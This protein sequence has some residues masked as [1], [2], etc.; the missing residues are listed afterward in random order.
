[1][2]GSRGTG[3]GSAA[4]PAPY[5]RPRSGDALS[6]STVL[7]VG[8]TGVF[9]SRLALGLLKE[10]GLDLVIAGR[11]LGAADAFCQ[12]HG[13]R[14]LR[15]D[16]TAPDLPPQVAALGPD[17]VIDAAGP[18]QGY[19][20]EPYSLRQAALACRAHCL[21]L[22]DDADVTL[23]VARLDEAARRRGVTVLPGAS[24]VPALPRPPSRNWPWGWPTST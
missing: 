22:S 14:P 16:R 9:G 8:G 6:N 10:L 24:S 19:G 20:P 21:D 2:T 12:R 11:D 15:L 1:M 5:P 13:G 4:V 23:G 7:I 17:L 3:T 18:F